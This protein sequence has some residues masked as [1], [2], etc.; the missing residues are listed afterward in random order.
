M[1]LTSAVNLPCSYDLD[2]KS[3]SN[4]LSNYNETIRTKLLETVANFMIRLVIL[5]DSKVAHFTTSL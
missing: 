4:N 5:R 2:S 3:G 1:L